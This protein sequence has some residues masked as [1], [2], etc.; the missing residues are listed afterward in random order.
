MCLVHSRPISRFTRRHL[1]YYVL[2]MIR[3]LLNILIYMSVIVV[4]DCIHIHDSNSN[5]INNTF[6]IVFAF[7]LDI[8]PERTLRYIP[9]IGQK[10][11]AVIWI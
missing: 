11:S 9:T 1:K 8:L 4:V 10:I 2:F 6:N 7:V 5:Y 3:Y